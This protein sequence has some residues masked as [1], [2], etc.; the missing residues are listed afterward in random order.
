MGRRRVVITGLGAICPIGTN[1]DEFWLNSLAGKTSV[2][3]IPE[4]WRAYSDF[5]SKI[6]SKLP[7]LEFKNWDLRR[8]DRLQY[9][10]VSLL[11]I[12][13]AREALTNSGYHIAVRDERA[14][15]FKV[16]ELETNRCGVFVGTGLGGGNS[17][18]ENYTHQVLSRKKREIS[19]LLKDLPKSEAN[20]SL[21]RSL[22]QLTHIPRFNPFVVSMLM[23]NATS[24]SI[25]I[26]FS[27]GGPNVT[28]SMACAAGTVSIGHAFK[29]IQTGEIDVAVAGG[30]EFLDDRYGAMFR[31]YDAAGV[32][33]HNF[34]DPE[35]ANCP[36]DKKRSGFLFSQGGAA[37][38]IL[39]ELETAKNRNAPIIAEVLGYGE[40]FDAY[41][42]MGMEPD[43]FGIERMIRLAVQDARIRAEKIQYI[44]AHGTGTF[45]N[46]QIESQI[47]ERIF[48]QNALIN[49]TKSLIGHTIGASGSLEAAITAL[50]LKHG[51]THICKNLTEPIANLNFVTE[52]LSHDLK[53]AFSQ[54]FAFGGHNAGIVMQRYG[55]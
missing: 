13:A 15:T 33:V 9:D 4:G 35:V 12:C 26:K 22:G 29:S 24:A 8:L 45:L 40:T 23:P 37:V 47:I 3:P 5:K 38:L 54:S 31:G 11:A 10:R 32:L 41:S 2:F 49:S 34:D 55:D 44:N 53:Y 17:F 28:F 36:F 25:G 42:M 7:P 27:I 52:V 46:D 43:G 21:Q 6:L 19:S 50:S 18:L 20:D 30:C 51:T 39:E 48:N 14:G 16:D 1:I